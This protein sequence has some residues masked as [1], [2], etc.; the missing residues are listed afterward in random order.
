MRWLSSAEQASARYDGGGLAALS[1][2]AR[3]CTAR[4]IR[5]TRLP[6]RSSAVNDPSVAPA[7]GGARMPPRRRAAAAGDAAPDPPVA[8]EPDTAAPLSLCAQHRVLMVSDFFYP[9]TGGV[10]V[11]IFQLAQRLMDRGHKARVC[12]RACVARKALT[13]QG[14]QVVVLTR[15]HG[16][17]GG[18]RH[19]TRGLK[20]YYAPRRPVRCAWPCARR[21]ARTAAPSRC[22][23]AVADVACGLVAPRCMAE[24][25]CRVCSASRACC[26]ASSS[27]SASRSCTATPP[28]G[29][30]CIPH[31]SPRPARALIRPLPPSALANEAVLHARTL[32]LK[33]VFTDHSLFGFADAS[34]I[35]TNKTLQFTLADTHHVVCVSHT[36]KQNTVLRADVAPERCGWLFYQSA[37]PAPCVLTWQCA[38]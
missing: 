20:V 36:S 9:N 37:C 11:H 8:A 16:A 4:N 17:R 19:M 32:G 10:E 1:K 27:A 22:P 13:R 14:A 26:A 34:S 7:R 31:R 2:R 21:T 28:S 35:L 5:A 25:R 23:P 29:A 18:V 15:A 12:W 38:A 3:A 30:P 6:S 33:A 24:R